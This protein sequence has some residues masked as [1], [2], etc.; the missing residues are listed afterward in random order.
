M[1]AATSGPALLL[2]A[3]RGLSVTPER[4][5]KLEASIAAYRNLETS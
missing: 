2:F 3:M 4:R 5:K 1:C